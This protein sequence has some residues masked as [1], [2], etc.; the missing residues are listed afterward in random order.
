MDKK[1]LFLFFMLTLL[2]SPVLDAH[3]QK[4][5]DEL[6]AGLTTVYLRV[7]YTD[8][9]GRSTGPESNQLLTDTERQLADTGLKLVSST[10]FERLVSSRG[11][12]IGTLNLQV[13]IDKV[14]GID[15]KVYYISL[16]L[17]QV[18]YVARKPVLRFFAPTWDITD[19]GLADDTAAVK[20]LVKD[21]VDRFVSDYRSENPK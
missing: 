14:T 2:V 11:Y 15:A 20:K 18:C 16:R 13:R 19:A 7:Q 4:L 6:L 3:A 12:P 21:A 17:Q 5:G 1:K 9:S 8:E 10:E